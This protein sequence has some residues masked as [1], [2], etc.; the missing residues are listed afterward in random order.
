MLRKRSWPWKGCSRSASS[1][2]KMETPGGFAARRLCRSAVSESAAYAR[3]RIRCLRRRRIELIRDPAVHDDVE[4]RQGHGAVLQDHV[5]EPLDVELRP[6]LLLG[7][8]AQ[9]L[10][11]DLAHH[12][13]E[14]LAWPGDVAVHLGVDVLLVEGGVLLEHLHRILAAHTV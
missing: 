14:R 5:V 1:S 4:H 7:V 6:E 11:V 8:L 12:V 13:G 10:D 3:P 9:L 2:E